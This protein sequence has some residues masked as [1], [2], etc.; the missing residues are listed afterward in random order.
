MRKFLM[1]AAAFAAMV[2]STSFALAAFPDLTRIYR[3]TGAMSTTQTSSA[4]IQTT[5]LCT[6]WAAAQANTRMT[7]RIV[8]AGATAFTD[9][10]DIAIQALGTIAVSTWNTLAFSENNTFNQNFGFTHGS[11]EVLAT[12][13]QVHCSA[14]VLEG[15]FQNPFFTIPLVGVRYNQE[16]GAQE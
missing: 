15:G 2:G 10:V 12:R 13:S 16:S 11:I 14:V 3:F 1:A 5:V 6:N 8:G 9:S 4:G 7:V